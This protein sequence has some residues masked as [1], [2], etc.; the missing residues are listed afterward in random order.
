MILVTIR[1]SPYR[2]AQAVLYTVN[3]LLTR[4][5]W[6]AHV[7]KSLPIP[8]GQGAV[9]VANHRSSVDPFFV[10]LA[11][12]RVVHWMVAKEY[13]QHVILGWFL[14]TVE[15]IPTNRWGMDT[16][17]TRKTIRLASQGNVVG[18]FPEGRINMTNNLLLP[19]RPGAALIALRAR[20][21]L[22]PCYIEG[23]PFDC[24][25]LSPFFM[26]ARVRVVFGEPI[27]LSDFHD[28]ERDSQ[29]LREITRN[30]MKQIAVLAGHSDFEPA[31]AGRDWKPSDEQ[32]RREMEMSR[33]HAAHHL[34]AKSGSGASRPQR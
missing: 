34:S 23:A 21:P 28:R 6:R 19:A 33:R 25:P 24:Y 27:D 20:V 32:V 8:L 9:M 14:R 5:L 31:L 3:L 11:A 30:A 15:V 12:K 13:V 1:R 17:A 2:P 29:V 26:T 18:V 16:A 7:P 4:L 10:Q 22:V